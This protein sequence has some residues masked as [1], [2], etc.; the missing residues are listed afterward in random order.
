M[1]KHII[2]HIARIVL[3]TFLVFAGIGHLTFDRNTFQSQ[4][5]QWV[6]VNADAVV[7]LSGIIEIL[8]GAALI[9]APKKQ[10]PVV[11]IIIAVFFI[12]V[13]PGNIAQYVDHRNAFGLDTDA[14]R[15][16]RLFFQPLLI[17]WAWKCTQKEPAN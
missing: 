10:R 12:A 17:Y 11:G 3:G 1:K 7:V 13:F 15:L 8:M 2:K 5:P 9:V 14:K 6:P 4:V 16:I